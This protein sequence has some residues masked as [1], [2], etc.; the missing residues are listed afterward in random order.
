MYTNPISMA[1]SLIF[2][3]SVLL[4]RMQPFDHY[5]LW[6]NP[7]NQSFWPDPTLLTIVFFEPI[8][9]TNPSDQIQPFW[10]LSS[11][12]QSLKPMLLTRS[13]P[14]DHCLL[15]TNPSNQSFWPR[16]NLLIINFLKAILH[17]TISVKVVL[18]DYLYN[19][20]ANPSYFTGTMNAIDRKPLHYIQLLSR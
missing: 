18:L 4:T 17:V 1:I 10:P 19:N 2:L 8:P 16:S 5:L 14:F 11:L 6:T 15:W 3:Q 7:S 13:N 20:K 12:N 9:Q